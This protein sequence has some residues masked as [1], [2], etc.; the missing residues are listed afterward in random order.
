MIT[1]FGNVINDLLQSDKL[2]QIATFYTAAVNLPIY[3]TIY[4]GTPIAIMQGF[5]GAAGAA[6]QLEEL[7]AMGFSK[8]IV[9]GA[10]GVLQKGIQVGHLI[11]PDKAVRDEG[12]SYHYVEPSREIE[13]NQHAINIIEKVLQV[14]DRAVRVDC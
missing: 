6:V 5:L 12:V 7:I 13:C 1:Y 4:N 11:V 8:F 10:A 3:E 9:C 14:E 2:K